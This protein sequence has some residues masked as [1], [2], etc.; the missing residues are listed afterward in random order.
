[1]EDKLKNRNHI[2]YFIDHLELNPPLLDRI[3]KEM[4]DFIFSDKEKILIL[5]SYTKDLNISEGAVCHE[6]LEMR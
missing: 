6:T 2:L 4:E 3:Y 5:Y 1:M